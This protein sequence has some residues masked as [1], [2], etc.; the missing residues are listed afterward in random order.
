MIIGGV[1]RF[2]GFQKAK[3]IL[4]INYIKIVQA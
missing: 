2:Q 3:I 1:Q 4:M